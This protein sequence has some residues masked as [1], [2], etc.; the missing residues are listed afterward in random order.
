MPKFRAQYDKLRLQA[1]RDPSWRQRLGA[2][3]ANVEINP[4]DVLGPDLWQP[5]APPDEI[6][7]GP[8]DVRTRWFQEQRAAHNAAR[9]DEAR[10]ILLRRHQLGATA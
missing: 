4:D 5:P 2:V 7:N 3:S 10:A 9:L 6:N 8:D 1:Q